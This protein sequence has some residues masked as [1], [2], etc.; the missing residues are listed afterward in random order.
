M[1]LV[2]LLVGEAAGPGEELEPVEEPVAAEVERPEIETEIEELSNLWTSGNKNEVVRRSLEMDNET[3]VKLVFA[4]GF[5]GA[6]EL[7]RM[8]DQ[9]ELTSEQDTT[10]PEAIEPPQTEEPREPELAHRITGHEHS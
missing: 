10:E 6:L 8:V 2:R 4:I 9:A 7:A 3:S 1:E 5:D